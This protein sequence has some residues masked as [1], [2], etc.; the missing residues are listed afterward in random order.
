L[1]SSLNTPDIE[2][3]DFHDEARAWLLIMV[4]A[5]STASHQTAVVASTSD[6]GIHWA[7]TPKFQIDGAATAVQFVDDLTGWVFATPS[8]GGA[9]GAG[10]TTLYR[11]VDGGQHWQ[12]IKPPS[13]VRQTGVV[14]GLPEACPMGGPVGRPTFT[15]DATGWIGA[16]CSRPFFYATHDGGLSWKP[17][18]LP[19]FPGPAGGSV[20]SLSFNVDSFQRQSINTFSV[21]VHR[22][23]TT[24][25]NAL[26]D[27][28]LYRTDDAGSSWRAIRL[29]AAELV[30]EFT[31]AN[32]GWMIA[33]GAGGNTEARSLY[34]TADGGRTW[35]FVDGPA[36]YY[37]SGLNFVDRTTGFLAVSATQDSAPEFLRTSDGGKS[38]AGVP[39]TIS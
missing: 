6:S 37:A 30:D 19:P 13:E 39:T 11:T 4:G 7:A 27:A 3:A 12:P 9:M 34:R 8:A 33:A 1:P 26:Q 22:G 2:A 23:V 25:G 31:S 28:A 29:P 32:D 16:F 17:V 18:A 21:V 14:A 24:G 5:E 10:D 35:L 20:A 36:G 15:D 38:W